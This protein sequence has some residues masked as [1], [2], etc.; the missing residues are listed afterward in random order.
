MTM[1]LDKDALVNEKR[2]LYLQ[3]V[4]ATLLPLKTK[5]FQ[6]ETLTGQRVAGK[7]NPAIQVT[8]P[9]GK[10]FQLY[11]DKDSHLPARQVAEVQGFNGDKFTQETTFEKYKAFDGIQKATHIENKRDGEPFLFLDVT[12][13]KALSKV[14]SDAFAE[15]K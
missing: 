10:T 14:D 1:E 11:F 8:G 6:I 7:D 3:V 2:N 4:P 9:D 12:E 15:P 13:F 5:A